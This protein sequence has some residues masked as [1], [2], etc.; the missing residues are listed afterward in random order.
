MPSERDTGFFV[1]WAAPPPGLRRFLAVSAA[2]LIAAFALAGYLLAV[3]ADDPGDGAFRFDWGQQT[4]VGRLDAEPYPVVHVVEAQRYAPGTPVMLSGVGKR[5]VQERAGP[6]DGRIVSVR[7]IAL[8]R[9][10][11]DMIQVADADAAFALVEA[12]DLVEPMTA[13]DLG[14]WRLTGEICDGKC[15]S[16][17]MRPGDGLAHR[18]CANLCLIGGVPPVFVSTGPVDGT[19]FFLMADA[20]GHPVT[21]AVL[22]HVATLVDVEGNVERRG[23]LSVFRIDPSSI[24]PAQ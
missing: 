24:R 15:Y 21:E 18:A 12:S 13:E 17:A 1:G 2:A 3:T 8:K 16:G 19:E 20:D 5:G 9:G 22:A 7:G 23:R 11:L 4:V 6:L 14:R 10:D